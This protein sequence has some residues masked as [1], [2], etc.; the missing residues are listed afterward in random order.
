MSGARGARGRR[1]LRWGSEGEP[2]NALELWDIHEGERHEITGPE[3]V[4]IHRQQAQ[5]A[6]LRSP[7]CWMCGPGLNLQRQTQVAQ[8]LSAQILASGFRHLRVVTRDGV[9]TTQCDLIR[10]EHSSILC[11]VHALELR[12]RTL[13][14]HSTRARHFFG[15]PGRRTC[16]VLALLV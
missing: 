7:R 11:G 6:H 3:V 16:T 5:I 10:A 13:A 14:S 2:S 8:L 9:C 4:L 12:S 1:W 15:L